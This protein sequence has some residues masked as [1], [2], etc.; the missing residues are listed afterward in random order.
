MR[1][2]SNYRRRGI[3]E[4]SS[5]AVCPATQTPIPV[6]RAAVEAAL[7]KSGRWLV[8][9]VLC[10][11]ATSGCNQDDSGNPAAAEAGSSMVTEA[12]TGGDAASGDQAAAGDPAVFT[13]TEKVRGLEH[14]TSLVFLPDGSLLVGE[15]SG[16]LRRIGGSGFI[17]TP[18][19]GVPPVSAQGG[20]LDVALSPKFATDGL[21]Y[22]SYVEPGEDGSVG[23]VVARGILEP[24]AL[25][26]VQVIY[27]Q[28]GLVVP[29]ETGGRLAFDA[30]GNLFVGSGERSAPAGTNLSSVSGGELLRIDAAGKVPRDNPLAGRGDGREEVWSYGH[31]SIHGLAFDPRTGKLWLAE[32]WSR[33]GDVLNLPQAGL[34]YGP[35]PVPAAPPVQPVLPPAPAIA[36]PPQSP[37][38]A[39][40]APHH[41]WSEPQG[42]SGMAF[43]TGRPGDPWNDSLFLGSKSG[44]DLI[45]LSLEG[46]RVVGEQR[47]LGEPGQ[48]IGDVKIDAS[49]NIFV[50]TDEPDGKLLQI[51]PPASR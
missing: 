10:L 15:R 17:S 28:P 20:L 40:R 11:A 44:G 27:R 13:V 51:V 4:M 24:L 22:L 48:P 6:R 2:C 14:P 29:R 21:L 32:N 50:L 34:D 12:A 31:G 3:D 41:R 46:D 7:L 37:V 23:L 16:T 49:G 25:L 35:E 1:N 43:Y 5:P 45:R 26:D 36:E 42:L 30:N 18:L 38:A 47:L 39:P 33:G 9:S 8:A 19:A